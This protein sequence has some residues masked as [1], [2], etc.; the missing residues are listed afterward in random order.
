MTILVVDDEP[1][2]RML[3]RDLLMTRGHDVLTAENGEDALRKL[4]VVHPDIVVS[5]VYMPVM[6]GV[7]FHKAVRETPQYAKLP[8]LFVSGY[9]DE[10]VLRSAPDPRY[11]GFLQKGR[12][13]RE[14]NEWIQH[15]TTPE[16]NR[17]KWLPG[18]VARS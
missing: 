13:P 9:S 11:D 8:F 18:E 10:Y 2:H 12:S 14:L 16:E 3:V 6:D 5:D 15:L 7:K 17:S 4:A 1:V